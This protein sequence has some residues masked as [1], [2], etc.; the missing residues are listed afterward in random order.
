M[1]ITPYIHFVTYV[2]IDKTRIQMKLLTL[3]LNF[4][5]PNF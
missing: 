5:E 4:F 2:S 3:A 1:K